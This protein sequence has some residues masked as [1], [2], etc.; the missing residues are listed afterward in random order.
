MQV[1]E[2]YLSRLRSAVRSNPSTFDKDDV[3]SAGLLLQQPLV[4]P[5]LLCSH[6]MEERGAER[7]MESPHQFSHHVIGK[8]CCGVDDLFIGLRRL[9]FLR[10]LC[11]FACVRELFSVTR[12][13]SFFVCLSSLCVCFPSS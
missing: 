11:V 12:S 7:L 9:A 3:T 4:Q 5:L 2:K 8:Y 6:L 13:F 1:T 10:L